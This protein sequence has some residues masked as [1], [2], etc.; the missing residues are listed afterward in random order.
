MTP[1]YVITALIVVAAVAV[2]AV[3]RLAQ[4]GKQIEAEQAARLAQAQRAK[5]VVVQLG[6]SVA[7]TRNGTVIIKLRLEVTPPN[8]P[9]YPVTT[10]WEVAQ[11][12]LPQI[13]PHQTVTVKIDA[14][15]PHKIYPAMNG[16]EFSE[17]YWGAWVKE[18]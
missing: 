2:A 12:N 17:L 3:R 11:A 18:K 5:A 15:D 4:Q 14:A 8:A 6:K 1:F 16:A 7:Q 10:V 13:Q 9:M